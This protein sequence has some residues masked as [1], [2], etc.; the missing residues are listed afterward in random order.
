MRRSLLIADGDGAMCGV[1][2][3]YFSSAGYRVET[4]SDGMACMNRLRETCPDLLLLDHQLPWGGGD[5]V[6]AC[7]R[8][9]KSIARVPVVLFADFI[10]IQEMSRL[11][12]RPVIRCLEKRCS[13]QTLRYCVDSALALSDVRRSVHHRQLSAPNLGR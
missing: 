1:Y 2:Q 6:L 11:L 9:D 4:V 10:P 8:E 5:G 3:S 12:I 7:L 13:V